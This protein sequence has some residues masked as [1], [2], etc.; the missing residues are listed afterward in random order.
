MNLPIVNVFSNPYE[1]WTTRTATP[2]EMQEHY[3]QHG[4]FSTVVNDALKARISNHVDAASYMANYG[5]DNGLESFIDS[6]L[7]QSP[8][9]KLLRKAMPS[10]TSK[11]LF[12]FQQKYPH[13]STVDV[14]REINNIG[15][16]LSH[17]QYL[18][19]GGMWPNCAS[20]QI[21]LKSPFSTS[22][23][24]QAA[25]RNA[26]WQGKAYDAN[27][28]DLF[29]LCAVEPKTNIFAFPRKGT[30]MGNEKE[31]LFA[32]GANLILRNRILIRNDYTVGKY[33][34]PD[35]KVPIYVIE[36]DVS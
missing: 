14:D 27:R 26:E 22:F 4:F 29:V 34:F 6:F 9:Y 31:V 13:F 1:A 7:D 10:R 35:K 33:G 18:F 12:D 28:I 25:L 2:E 23:C 20:G 19:H 30:R 36:V 17:G 24:P 16:T 8:D 15:C 32:S 21:V 3:R 11:V 5:A